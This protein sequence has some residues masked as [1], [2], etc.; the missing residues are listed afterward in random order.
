VKKIFMGV[1][2]AFGAIP[3]LAT[4]TKG[5]AA[6]PHAKLLFGGF[7]EAIGAAILILLWINRDQLQKL[8]QGKLIRLVVLMF[9]GS[10]VAFVCYLAM[11]DWC[12][13]TDPQFGT[14]MYPLWV[15]GDLATIIRRAGGRWAALDLYGT[16]AVVTSVERS[17]SVVWALTL[18]SFL[19]L[20]QG[21]FSF[22]T[23]AFGLLAAREESQSITGGKSKRRQRPSQRVST[24]RRRVT[25]V[26]S[27]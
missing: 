5:L 17:S 27:V 21:I 16:Y 13:V 1:A 14:V 3:G 22:A 6:P 26:E 23:V 12:I 8:S 18:G 4:V 7:V 25:G 24:G 2:A 20:Y 11:Y 10:F 15:T 9:I 19:L